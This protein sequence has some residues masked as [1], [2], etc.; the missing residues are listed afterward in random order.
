MGVKLF[1]RQRRNRWKLKLATAFFQYPFNR[2]RH[3]LVW[4]SEDICGNQ[5]SRRWPHFD[6]A[7]IV[8][9]LVRSRNSVDYRQCGVEQRGE[10]KCT[11]DHSTPRHAALSR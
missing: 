1:L 8:G 5:A 10:R 3:M 6:F 7:L 4:T 11:L 9:G 2:R